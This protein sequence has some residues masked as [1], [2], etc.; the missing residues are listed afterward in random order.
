[1]SRRNRDW[2][3]EHSQYTTAHIQEIKE[4]MGPNTKVVISED[5][6]V[7]LTSIEERVVNKREVSLKLSVESQFIQVYL[8]FY[9]RLISKGHASSSQALL[10][11]VLKYKI[12]SENY[13]LV[14][15]KFYEDLID[16]VEYLSGK[17]YHIRTLK[18]VMKQMVKDGFFIRESRGNYRVNPE[19]FWTDTGQRRKDKIFELAEDKLLELPMKGGKEK[20]RRIGKENEDGTIS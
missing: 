4:K 17:T 10:T 15:Q 16:Y 13:F 18:D 3:E 1:M 20:T 19:G 7:T 12:D 11:F 8:G 2:R 14:N 5:G 6:N 9:E